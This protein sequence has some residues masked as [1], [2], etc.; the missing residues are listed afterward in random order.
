LTSCQGLDASIEHHQHHHKE[1]IDA[2][3]NGDLKF[4]KWVR[5]SP[6]VRGAPTGLCT[7]EW[8]EEEEAGS[9]L[10]A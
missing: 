6:R 3:T 1:G 8:E 2:N 10:S 9:Q 4:N 5:D 7:S